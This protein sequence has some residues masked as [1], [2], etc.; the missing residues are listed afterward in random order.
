MSNNNIADYNMGQY[1]ELEIS[2]YC[3]C[4]ICNGPYHDFSNSYES[5]AANLEIKGNEIE[6][7]NLREMRRRI[8][9]EIVRKRVDS[10]VSAV[11]END[12][13][14]KKQYR[15]WT[16]SPLQGRSE[17][18]GCSHKRRCDIAEEKDIKKR[19]RKDGYL[20]RGHYH[21]RTR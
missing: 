14:H 16:S 19:Q 11:E 21:E 18:Q 13:Y 3:E 10:S 7:D 20:Y 5:N 12:Y 8:F 4:A 6:E 15:Q 17:T 2:F 1:V 9:D